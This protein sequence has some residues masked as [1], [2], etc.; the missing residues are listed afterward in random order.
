[1]SSFLRAM[2]LGALLLSTRLA[3]AQTS[4]TEVTPS[5]LPLWV[6]SENTDFWVNS[7][8]PAD[9][10]GDGDLDLAVIGLFVVYNVSADARLVLFLNNGQAPNGRWSFTTREVALNGVFAGS[11]DLAWGDFDRDG[12]PDLAVGSEGDTVIYRNDA[13]FLTALP[14]ALPAYNEASGY[15]GAYDLRSM[16]WAD[17]DNDGDVD[18][19]IPSIFDRAAFQWQTRLLRNDGS[20]EAGGWLFTEAGTDLPPTQH[21]QTVWADDDNDGDLDLFMVNIDE[22]R[23]RDF[24]RRFENHGGTFV[25]R[26]L[27]GI[28]IT[29]GSMDWGDYDVDGDMDI[30]VAG[31]IEETNGTFDTVLR[32]Y[33]NDGG[34]VYTPINLPAPSPNWLDFHAVSWAD[35]NSDGVMDLLV[36]GSFVGD[37]EIVGGS[38][39]YLNQGGTFVAAGANLSAPIESIGRGGTFSWLDIDGDGDLDYL[40]A[41]AYFVPD[42]NGLVEA[43]IHLYRNDAVLPNRAPARPTGLSSTDLGNGNVR[44]SWNTS[45]DDSTAGRALTY[46][47]E[48]A[49][50]TELTELAGAPRRR[51]PESGSVSAVRNWRLRGMPA[52]VYDWSVRAVDSAYNGSPRA[53]GSI[54]V[55]RSP[56]PAVD[57]V[58]PLPGS[59]LKGNV[60]IRVAATD[61]LDA[62]GEL[63][64]AVFVGGEQL[65]LPTAWDPQSQL[66]RAVWRTTTVPDGSYT[67]RAFAAD[68]NGNRGQSRRI[69]IKVDNVP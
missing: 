11:S 10:D 63:R 7:V 47:L 19:L 15:S 65:L 21:A 57:L 23:E 32:I 53:F 55:T 45:F 13:G 9:V 17:A 4:F 3:V 67:L 31:N 35:Y 64:V 37:S 52:G 50:R 1:M 69:T 60:L 39:I 33:R 51:L 30:V 20:D 28:K 58:R 29:Y 26:E 36:T 27:L 43:Q 40:V 42:G 12:D 66:Y 6:T 34:G 44:L 41:G 22:D 18:L 62:G 48:I 54:T 5:G 25:G 8:A 24:I 2:T 38:E 59:T 49:R 14:N 56:V 46:D 16:T 68:K 61:D